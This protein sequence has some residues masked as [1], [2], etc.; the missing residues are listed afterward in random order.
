MAHQAHNIPWEALASSYKL[1][2]VGPRGTSER[3]T[4]FEAIPGEAAEKKR[5]HFVRVFLRTLEEFSESERRK[6][7]EVTIEDDD[8]DDDTPI[9]GDEAVRKVYAYFESPYGEPRGDDIDGQRTG[10][11]WKDPFDTVS[12]RRAGIV[13]ALIATNEIEPLLRLAK[14]KSRPLQRVLQYM[15]ADPGWRNLFQTALTAYLFLNL[16][17]TRPQL[18]MPEGSEGGGK[19]FQRDYRDMEGC[20]RML[21][22]CTEGRE[23]D[24]WAI[25]HREFFGR[26][27]SYFEDS[28]KLKEE[29]VDPLNP[30]NLER[31]R[32][33]LKLCWNHLVRSHV[34]AKEAGLD[35]DWE[36]YIK[37]EISWLISY[38]SFVEFY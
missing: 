27:F 33:Y 31:L 20:R 18:W 26:E 3:H 30:G 8:D 37:T 13:M 36:S 14:L 6:Y 28:T 11:G 9:F 10:R 12:D 7:P 21:K 38:G 25:P 23:Q 34:V 35:I 24:T 4:V 32:D 1:A 29:G 19:D 2:K 15:G 5:M 16:V 17:Y 22:G